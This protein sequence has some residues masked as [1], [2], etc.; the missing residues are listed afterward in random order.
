MVGRLV[1]EKGIFELI[2]AAESLGSHVRILVAGPNDPAKDDAISSAMLD[3][4]AKAG[5]EFV[6][7]R[8]DIDV[9]YAALDIFVLPSHR[10][11][12]P[13]AA[14]E[15]AASGLPLVLTDIRGCR[16]VVEHQVNG[17][18][19]PVG[20][21]GEL[22]SAIGKLVSDPH[23]R[24]IMG[25]ASAQ[26]ARDQ[27]DESRVVEI[28]MNTYHRLAME[29]GIGWKAP[30]QS[31]SVLI[32]PAAIFEART[33]ARLHIETIDSG[34]L[35]SLGPS[36]LTLLYRVLVSSRMG[37]VLVADDGNTV[38]GFIAGVDD[39]GAF[40]KEFLRKH[41]I[42]ALVRMVPSLIRPGTWRRIWETFRYG[43]SE[44]ESVAAELLAMG[45]APSARR[46]GLG[47]RLVD[48][49]LDE[50]AV[51]DVDVMK[52]VV[53]AT[54]SAAIDMYKASGFGTAQVTE[55]HQG[56]ESLELIWRS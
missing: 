10:E 29:K 53:G 6:G 33:V 44:K 30:I 8:E 45:V 55:V 50:A 48:A 14:M 2:E 1:A 27:F 54:N 18:L 32:R 43:S 7:M 49:L 5:V 46:K 16:Q 37:T 21:A 15:A 3:R 47:S 42:E 38:V 13:R 26:R 19:V 31:T 22:A 23:L 40:Y 41:L 20:D 17:S 51:N 4:G 35:S 52:V 12:F 28:V 24:E 25:A 39:T 11:G 34:F 9:F 56:V 36:F